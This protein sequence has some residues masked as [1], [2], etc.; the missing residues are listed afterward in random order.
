MKG[1][2]I[3]LTFIIGIIINIFWVSA[4]YILPPSSVYYVY[5]PNGTPVESLKYQFDMSDD[6]KQSLISDFN[7]FEIIGEP[8]FYYNCHAYDWHIKGE[9]V[10][11]MSSQS[12]WISNPIAYINDNSYD[13]I[14]MTNIS[15]GDI[16]TYW[17]I[18]MLNW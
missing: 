6:N 7:S 3:S 13:E 12:C 16:V 18:I 9:Y 15:E 2:F 1:K 5:T 17:K 14:T 4:N 11:A 8:T 10:P